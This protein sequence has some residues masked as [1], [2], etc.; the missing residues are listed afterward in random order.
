MS[1][2]EPQSQETFEQSLA[3]LEKITAQLEDPGTGLEDAIALYETGTELAKLCMDRLRSAEQRVEKLSEAL[4]ED[5]T[6]EPPT[7]P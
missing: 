7:D 3:R 1:S 6:P 4:A 2:K 5:T